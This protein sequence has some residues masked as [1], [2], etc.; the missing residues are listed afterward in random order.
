[1]ALRQMWG[2]R[3]AGGAAA[4]GADSDE[5]EDGEEGEEG[6]D[7]D[8]LDFEALSGDLSLDAVIGAYAKVLPV[9]LGAGGR[10]TLSSMP[11]FPMPFPALP[12][13]DS[14]CKDV[15]RRPT[16]PKSTSWIVTETGRKPFRLTKKW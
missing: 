6:S 14:R 15:R 16:S 8:E 5:D 12:L 3:D 10:Q 1:M 7:A 11:C 13:R 4:S 9:P 2:P